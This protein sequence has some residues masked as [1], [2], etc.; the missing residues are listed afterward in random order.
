MIEVLYY[1]AVATAITAALSDWRRG[2]YLALFFEAL[3]DPVRKISD[4]HSVLVTI[5]AGMVWAAVLL[6]CSRKLGPRLF[7]VLRHIPYL[8]NATTC[9]FVALAPAVGVSSVL[10][11]GGYRVAIVGFASYTLPILGMAVGYHMARKPENIWRLLRY[12]CVVNVVVLTGTFLEFYKIDVPGL[13]SVPDQNGVVFKWIRYEPGYIVDLMCGFYRSPDVMG[14]HAANVAMFSAL[15]SLQPRIRFRWLWIGLIVFSGFC[16]MLSGRRK[17]IGMF[18]VFA[19]V[20]VGL[21]LR[22]SGATRVIPILSAIGA[23]AVMVFGVM[24]GGEDTSEYATYAQTTITASGS[25]LHDNV[26]VGVL[27]SLQQTGILGI[28]L[29][30]ATQGRYYAEADVTAKTWQ[31]DGISRI[32]AEMGLFG[33]LFSA[34]AA[35]YFMR[36]AYAAYIMVPS[37]TA[38]REL[39]I[40]MIGVVLA[41]G[42]SFIVSHQAFSGD[43]CALLFAAFLF[44]VMLSG[45]IQIMWQLAAVE[46]RHAFIAQELA[47]PLPRP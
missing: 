18:V 22:Q 23:V 15:L 14:L 1:A 5:A 34:A 45:P 20:Y 43:P 3:R 27:D 38:V 37:G 30:T 17:M 39:Q 42:A 9:L 19:V 11:S 13:G 6:G 4:R 7:A 8:R 47:R 46:E 36:G 21:R 28:G 40:G 29:G 31:E 16:L 26:F 44:G 32:F 25:R 12:Y 10:Y 2:M 24:S 41:T 33:A 35:Y